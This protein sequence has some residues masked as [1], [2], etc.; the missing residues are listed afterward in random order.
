MPRRDTTGEGD[1]PPEAA[2]TNTR[3]GRRH[4]LVGWAPAGDSAGLP[5]VRVGHAGCRRTGRVPRVGGRL[6]RRRLRG[7]PLGCLRALAATR[8]RRRSR[9]G[10]VDGRLRRFRDRTGRV[11]RVGRDRLAVLLLQ[12][13]TGLAGVAGR[14]GG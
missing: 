13:V 1:I 4:T 3:P 11:V 14:A 12:A 9:L 8:L 2:D 7:R 10:R 5:G 6:R